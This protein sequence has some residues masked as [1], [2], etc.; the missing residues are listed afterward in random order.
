MI[1]LTAGAAQRPGETRLHLLKRN[2]AIVEEATAEIARRKSPAVL[3][4]VTNPVD[5]TTRV[6]LRASGWEKKRVIGSGTVLD[7]ARLPHLLSAHC[8]VDAHN[9]HA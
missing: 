2:A 1:V 3:V 9:V 8:G 4:V 6:A 5:L 7:S